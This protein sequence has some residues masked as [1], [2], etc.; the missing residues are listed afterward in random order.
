MGWLPGAGAWPQLLQVAPALKPLVPLTQCCTRL[1]PATLH[2]PTVTAS[3][4]A[5]AALTSAADAAIQTQLQATPV[6]PPLPP[7]PLSW[8]CSRE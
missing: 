2:P 6:L 5:T 3:L 8:S 4:T 1:L 7:C